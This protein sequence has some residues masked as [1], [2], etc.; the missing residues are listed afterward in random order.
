AKAGFY[1]MRRPRTVDSVRCFMCDID[2]GHWKPGQSPYARHATESPTCPWVLLNYPDA[3]A[4]TNKALT[5]NERDPTTQP[6]HKVMKSARLATF[7]HH[8]YWP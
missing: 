5:V 6:R 3:A 4:S 1:F 2:L 7:N 8:H